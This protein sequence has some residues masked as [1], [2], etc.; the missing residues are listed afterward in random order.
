MKNL[1]H[2][3]S[4]SYA[5]LSSNEDGLN[6]FSVFAW[7]YLLTLFFSILNMSLLS[8]NKA[9]VGME[10]PEIHEKWG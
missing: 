3:F 1:R 2:G 4:F 6:V 7:P 5:Y 9:N 8:T 10:V